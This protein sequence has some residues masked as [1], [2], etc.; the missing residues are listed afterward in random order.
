M[1]VIERAVEAAGGQQELA[2]KCKVSYQAVQKWVKA[3]RIPPRR[4]LTVE[5]ASGVSRHDL[6]SDLYPRDSAA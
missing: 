4:V 5:A 1:N 2:K 6:R 3:K